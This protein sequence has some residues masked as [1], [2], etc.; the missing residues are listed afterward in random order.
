M[1]QLIN[2][3]SPGLFFMQL[4]IFLVLLL[5]LSKFAWK[6][7]LNSLKAREGSIADALQAAENAKEEMAKL[8][9][10]NQKLLQEARMERDKLLKEATD[11]ANKIKEEAKS[12]AA[13]QA[14]KMIAD[15][16]NSIEVEKNAALKEVT[17]KV[18]ELSL[19]IAEKVIRKNL[20][21]DKAQKALAEDFMKELKLN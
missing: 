7:I 13:K 14:D 19:E 1:E 5:L 4:I 10:D 18:A 8:Q 17:T 11:I 21:D 20:S 6:P 12:D 3:F 9:A 16:K 15:A 2:D